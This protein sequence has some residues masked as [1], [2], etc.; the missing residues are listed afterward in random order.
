MIPTRLVLSGYTRFMTSNHD[1]FEIHFNHPLQIILGTNGSGKS[2]LLTEATP[3]PSHHSNFTKGGYR[4]FEGHHNHLHYVLRSDYNGGTGKHSFYCVEEDRELNPGGTY[5]AQIDLVESVFDWDR[6]LMD[7]LLG[8][9]RFTKMSTAERRRWLTRLCP[10][11][12]DHVFGLLKTCAS[13][14]RDQKGVLSMVS[15]RLVEDVDV[16]EVD[17]DA[18]QHTANQH[19][20]ALEGLYQRREQLPSVIPNVQADYDRWV[21]KVKT[22]LRSSIALPNGLTCKSADDLSERRM[23]IRSQ[24]TTTDD[25]IKTTVQRIDDVQRELAQY[26]DLS[27]ESLGS[28]K[29]Q[30]LV[31]EQEAARI[32]HEHS[33][34]TVKLPDVTVPDVAD[35]TSLFH[36]FKQLLETIPDNPDGRM[37][38]GDAVTKRAELK[39]LEPQCQLLH[40][41]LDAIN[42]RLQLIKE[43]EDITCPNC[44]HL[45]KPNVSPQE[46]SKLLERKELLENNIRPLE[47]KIEGLRAYMTE[48][49]E[50][51]QFVVAYREL[52]QRFGWAAEFWKYCS[53]HRIPF[54]SPTAIIPELHMWYDRQTLG[55]QLRRVNASYQEYKEKID[56]IA[57]LDTTALVRRK[58]E[59]LA[60]EEQLVTYQQRKL[61]L[62]EEYQTLERL[63]RDYQVYSDQ[64][65]ALLEE[66]GVLMEQA[67]LVIRDLYQRQLSTV[68]AEHQSQ[69]AAIDGEIRN[70]QFKRGAR[71]AL[72]DQ[73]MKALEDQRIYGALVDALN[74]QDG[75]I[76]QYLKASMGSIVDR[77]NAIIERVWSYPL[78][79]L[80]SPL[81]RD[82]LT[83]KFPLSVADQG[84]LTP[85]IELGSSAQRDIV[86]FAFNLT[87]RSCLGRTDI[88]LF[89]DELGASFDE[90]HRDNLI[91]MIET[92]MENQMVQQAFFISH[93]TST[94]GAFTHADVCVL[95]TTNITTPAVYNTHVAFKPS[96]N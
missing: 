4:I 63:L 31:Y 34:I 39:E 25:A 71:Q 69:V 70:I 66:H 35:L 21:N 9:K 54:R 92:M 73:K 16:K 15:K 83:Y 55:H 68:I 95:D 1:Y 6:E 10:V 22:H 41:E 30:A 40:N 78:K 23:V 50:Y 64:T 12:M 60:L 77:L 91:D 7:L 32:T 82:E 88:P 45:F 80:P 13:L 56:L 85:D 57:K 33:L 96:E 24:L 87:V 3:Y 20:V 84:L 67:G 38:K 61:Q 17:V 52:T 28:L 18:L 5:K 49:L 89:M 42:K 46:P 47:D 48:F 86:D 19:H 74:V 72:E 79:V 90:V 14:Q 27:P 29:E 53:D 2:S 81:E 65:H 37:N 58:E 51:H 75:L 36:S 44:Q 62:K 59:V 76:G 94:H 43:C 11:D 26:Q 93:Y 8:H